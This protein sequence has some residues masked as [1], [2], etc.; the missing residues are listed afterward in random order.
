M[1][2]IEL[3]IEALV[4]TILSDYKNGRDIDKI[5]SLRQPDQNEIVDII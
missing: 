4:D 2:E 5:E 1:N 3:Q